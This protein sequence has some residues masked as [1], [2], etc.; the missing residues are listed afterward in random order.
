MPPVEIGGVPY[1]DGGIGNNTPMRQAAYFARFVS[2]EGIGQV[3]P[4]ICVINDPSR[5]TI[6]NSPDLQD[7]FGVIRRTIDIFQ[8]ELVRDSLISWDRINKEV[9]L[10]RQK[11]ANLEAHIDSIAELTSQTRDTLKTEVR[12][13]L[14]AST[15]ATRRLDMDILV[16]RPSSPLVKNILAFDPREAKELKEQGTADCLGAF[17]HRRLIDQNEQMQWLEEIS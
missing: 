1:I 8:N 2:N 6:D 12:A 13:V 11:A 16:I 4:T 5:F 15:A 14:G 17:F 9:A 7:I 10:A 3:E